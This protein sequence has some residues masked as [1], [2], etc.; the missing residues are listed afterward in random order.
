MLSPLFGPDAH[1]DRRDENQ[2]NEGQPPAELVEVGQVVAE[3]IRR[4]ERG[5][6]REHHEH[7][8][9][10]VSGRVGKIADEIPPEDRFQYG[11]VHGYFGV[12][13]LASAATPTLFAFALFRKSGRREE[14]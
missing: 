1:R 2:Q 12:E 5:Q 8:N 9:E 4:P 3:E 6:R 14:W 11:P 10:Y 13:L 7:A